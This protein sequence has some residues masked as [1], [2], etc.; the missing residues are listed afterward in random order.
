MFL[1]AKRLIL[2]KSWV[3]LPQGLQ[4]IFWWPGNPTGP[5]WLPR[6]APSPSM[7][8]AVWHCLVSLKWN[9]DLHHVR[10]EVLLINWNWKSSKIE[11]VYTYKFIN[12]WVTSRRK[13]KKWSLWLPLGKV[14]GRLEDMGREELY[15]SLSPCTFSI[16]KDIYVL[17][18]IQKYVYCEWIS[19][20]LKIMF[21]LLQNLPIF[22]WNT[23]SF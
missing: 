3:R 16:Q 23:S 17:L 9:A 6:T 2:F 1:I 22:R 15:F 14:A 5:R 21:K 12:M 19:F 20:L 8:F 13:K 10:V 11:I 4:E 7:H 18:S